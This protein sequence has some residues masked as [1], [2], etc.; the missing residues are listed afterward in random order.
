LRYGAPPETVA[1]AF[2]TYADDPL[3][4]RKAALFVESFRPFGGRH[5]SAPVFVAGVEPGRRSYS[6]E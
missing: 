4:E 5:A 6:G 2:A 1:V 3:Q